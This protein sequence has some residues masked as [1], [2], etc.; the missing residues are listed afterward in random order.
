MNEYRVLCLGDVVGPEGVAYLRGHLW[1]VRKEYGIDLAVVNG[2]NADPGNGISAASADLLLA[3][4]ADVITSGN[5]IW[6]KKDMRD[7]LD[8]SEFILRP[9]NYPD[10]N[11][12]KGYALIDAGGARVLVMNVQGTAFMEPLADPFETVEKILARTAGKYDYAVLDVHAEATSEK[13]AL[14]RYF[15]GRIQVIVGTHTHVATA[16]ERILPGGSGYVTDLGMCGSENGI[17]GVAT[18][19]ILERMRFKMPVKFLLAEGNVRAHGCVF[20]IN[21]QNMCVNFVKRVEF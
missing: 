8:N 9:A 11:P 15:D 7:Y 17:L 6:Q 4:G 18:D 1:E 3:A 20:G 16:D 12:G 19:C 10:L 21:A 14:G 13:L 2:E 5:H